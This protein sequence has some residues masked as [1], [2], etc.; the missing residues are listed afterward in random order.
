MTREARDQFRVA[1][2]IMPRAVLHPAHIDPLGHRRVPSRLMRI[3]FRRNELMI[4]LKNGIKRYES[5]AD[6]THSNI[7]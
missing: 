1:P 2:G 5:K 7:L 3:R 4:P 6:Q